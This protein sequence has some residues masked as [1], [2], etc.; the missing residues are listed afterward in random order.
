MSEEH[1]TTNARN[2]KHL[3]AYQRGES[4]RFYGRGC[5]K[6]KLLT[7]LVLPVLPF[8]EVQRMSFRDWG[9][10]F[11]CCKRANVHLMSHTSP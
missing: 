1:S 3:T 7:R 8:L 2:F 9:N 5:P 10:H 4:K 6:R 11:A